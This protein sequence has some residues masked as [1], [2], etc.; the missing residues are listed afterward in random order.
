MKRL[1]DVVIGPCALLAATS[2]SAAPPVETAQLS[3]WYMEHAGTRT[4]QPCGE[5]RVLL[6][7]V[8]GDLPEES[9]KFGLEDDTPVYVRLSGRREDDSFAVS[10]VE[11]FGSPTP[12]R[13]C[14]LNGVVTTDK[15]PK[16]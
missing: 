10:A 7:S 3:G 9:R 14:G 8:A 6:V 11:Q 1:I 2:C 12:V 15:R 16:P 4:F 13:N 5:D